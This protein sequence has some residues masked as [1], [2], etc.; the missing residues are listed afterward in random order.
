MFFS[1]HICRRSQD[2]L[3]ARLLQQMIERLQASEKQMRE[4]M[5]QKVLCNVIIAKY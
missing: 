1:Q 2:D 4:E 5:K 3:E